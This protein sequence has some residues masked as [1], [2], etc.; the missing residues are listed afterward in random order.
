MIYSLQSRNEVLNEIT[1]LKYWPLY[2][3]EFKYFLDSYKRQMFLRK[4]EI[5]NKRILV[6]GQTVWKKIKNKRRK[7]ILWDN[8]KRK[9]IF[10][11][12]YFDFLLE[13]KNHKC[14][15]EV[16]VIYKGGT[17]FSL[18]SVTLTI[19]SN[20][21]LWQTWFSNH[22]HGINDQVIIFN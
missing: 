2:K 8:E 6:W 20:R 5:F 13:R 16:C 9:I 14:F 21:H 22:A 12:E 7:G 3:G 1:E 18:T 4:K 19:R 11:N 10:L 15:W 17:L